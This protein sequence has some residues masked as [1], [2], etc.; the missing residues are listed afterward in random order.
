MGLCSQGRKN[1]QP[2]S[3]A[4]MAGKHNRSKLRLNIQKDAYMNN[5]KRPFFGLAVLV[6]D[7]G[8]VSFME[9]DGLGVAPGTHAFSFL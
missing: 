4:R 9:E 2:L 6:H 1:G 8:S 5:S 7:Q 3:K